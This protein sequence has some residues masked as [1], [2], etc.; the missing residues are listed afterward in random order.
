MYSQ[1]IGTWMIFGFQPRYHKTTVM[2]DA[3]ILTH[4]PK[5]CIEFITRLNYSRS[6]PETENTPNPVSF[7]YCKSFSN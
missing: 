2:G 4:H 6:D 1:Y 7:L 5:S 3:N